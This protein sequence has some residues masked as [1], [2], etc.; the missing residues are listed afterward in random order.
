[1]YTHFG[2]ALATI[3]YKQ[4]SK[5]GIYLDTCLEWNVCAQA[6]FRQNIS[7]VTLYSN[8]NI[9]A[10][11]H[12]FN[13]TKLDGIMTNIT[14][15]EIILSMIE[16]L[17]LLK[18]MVVTS[19][20][21][22][23]RNQMLNMKENKTKTYLLYLISK[24]ISKGIMVYAYE[25]FMKL[26]ER[27]YVE[28]SEPLSTDIA[29]IMFT[30]GTTSMPK[31]VI[32]RHKNIISAIRGTFQLVIQGADFDEHTDRFISFLP[33]AHIL[34]FIVHYA[35]MSLGVPIGYASIPTLMD[36]YLKNSEGDFKALKPT[37]MVGAPA[38]FDTVKREI[39]KKVRHETPFKQSMF[40]MGFY[41]ANKET[42]KLKK[43]SEATYGYVP[44]YTSSTNKTQTFQQG[45]ENEKVDVSTFFRM[46]YNTSP[47]KMKKKLFSPIRDMFGGN[48]RLTISGGS[49]L[50]SST[51]SF[52]ETCLNVKVLEGYGLTETC[53][54][55][56]VQTFKDHRHHCVGQPLPT[57]EVRLVTTDDHIYSV[58]DKPF[59]R[60]EIW[61][62]GSSVATEYYKNKAETDK[63]F[64][65][66]G[67]FRTG[68]VGLKLMDGSL[69]IIDRIKNI[70]KP[71]HGKA[72]AVEA[73]ENLHSTIPLI[74]QICIYVD[75]SHNELVALIVPDLDMIAH[76]IPD[77]S[78]ISLCINQDK[79]IIDMI[80]KSIS[81]NEK[82]NYLKD[83]QHIH[84]IYLVSTEWTAD[85]GAL[86]TVHK[87]KRNFIT[88][89]Y[90]KEITDMYIRL[91]YDK[92]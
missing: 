66:D 92:N 3:G 11:K 51:K 23:A 49:A 16:D 77:E 9:D 65:E 37:I 80:K 81:N 90:K 67:W 26:G 72:V 83:F 22:K 31:G 42:N 76:K 21:Q 28:P 6:C 68:D 30:S 33:L 24:F 4:R 48:L 52:I 20:P 40:N 89:K 25:D 44:N 1:M 10:T 70:I 64:V 41:S 7:V 5:F 39:L 35:V 17:P 79:R 69:M 53:G 27:H 32:L 34:T 60:G 55:A 74:K 78:T 86:T 75:A 14:Q 19:I 85:N 36:V 29:T 8:L 18:Y 46:L 73:L 63:A 58:T 45:M 59:P 71:P 57:L 82:R 91:G 43:Q 84:S 38:F 62:R 88:E 54:P 15:L 47:K 13:L 56:S 87:K 2:S 61:L 50:S 12:V